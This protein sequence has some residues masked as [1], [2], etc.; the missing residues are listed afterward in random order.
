MQVEPVAAARENHVG[1]AFEG[2]AKKITL[3]MGR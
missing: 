3:S 2:K 1:E